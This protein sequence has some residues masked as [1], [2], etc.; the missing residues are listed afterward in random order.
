MAQIPSSF[1]AN[2]T[3][4]RRPG[5]SVDVASLTGA[6]VIRAARLLLSSDSDIIQDGAVV[7]K[8]ETIIS[9]GL[10]LAVQPTL[11]PDTEILDLGDVTLMPGLFDCHVHLSM[12]PSFF[13]TTGSAPPK[14]EELFARMQTNCFRVLDAG[15]TTV[16][17]LGC[18]G[19][20]STEFRDRI[21]AGVAQGPRILSANA[22]ITVPGGHANAWGGIA[23][24]VEGCRQEARKRIQEGVD[25]IKVMTTGGF[26]TPGSSPEKARYTVEELRAIAEEAHAHNIPVTTH[27][28][29]LEGIERAVDAGFDCIEHCAWSVEGGTRFDEEI[30]KKIVAK[31]VAVCPTMNTA[32]VEKD[33]FLPWD[34]REHVMKNLSRLRDHG[35]QM[36][37]G[38][39][40]GIGLCPFERYADGLSVL[41]EA[42]YSL[43]E[44]IASATDRASKVCGL[45]TVTGKLLPG[46]SADIVAFAGNPLESV[47]AFFNPRFVMARGRQHKLTPIPPPADNSEMAELISK[48]LR[49]GAGLTQ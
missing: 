48:L 31:N 22:P 3:P 41:V 4:D 47:E 20:Y 49:K 19:T 39:D 10:W 1:K 6:F 43:R 8:G 29:G 35:V 32:C 21:S 9:S 40:N 26:L 36:V 11:S 27:A 42:G 5:L 17:D 24:G 14:G 44:I 25:V 7:I 33:Y 28:T 38:T 13:A 45:S 37:V 12:D 30:A 46:M 23:S 18:P 16:R 15:V 34:A 2:N